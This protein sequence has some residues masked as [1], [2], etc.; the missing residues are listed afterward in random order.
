MKACDNGVV[1]AVVADCSNEGGCSDGRCMSP[2]CAAVERDRM[3]F[4]GCL[5]YTASSDNVASDVDAPTAFL[6]TNPG[7]R[8]RDRGYAAER[9]RLVGTRRCRGLSRRK[10]ALRLA[11]A[12]LQARGGRA[13]KRRACV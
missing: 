3:S 4:A 9:G 7:S 8:A 1:G 11:I 10:T 6:V 5:F 13:R 2:D 12:G